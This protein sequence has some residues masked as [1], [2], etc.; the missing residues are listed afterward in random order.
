MINLTRQS[1][2]L[3]GATAMLLRLR[4]SDLLNE[5]HTVSLRNDK[6]YSKAIID[7]LL[8]ERSNIERF[9]MRNCCIRFDNHE[10]D[11]R[12]KLIKCRAYFD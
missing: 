1:I 6:I 12:G 11:K 8:S 4:E 2:W 7:M 9:L 5:P 10:T 3:D